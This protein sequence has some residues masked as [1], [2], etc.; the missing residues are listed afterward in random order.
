MDEILEF[1]IL[2]NSFF[3]GFENLT[4]EDK[5]ES[6]V[7]L[8]LIKADKIEAVS[9]KILA[10]IFDSHNNHGLGNIPLK[11]LF[12]LLGIKDKVPR[13]SK[14]KEEISCFY[15]R[16]IKTNGRM[17]L[18]I[19]ASPYLFLIENKIRHNLDNPLDTYR[20]WVEKNYD[21]NHGFT[22]KYYIVL[23]INKPKEDL[24][25][26]KFVSHH[27]LVSKIIECRGENSSTGS[28]HLTPFIEDYFRAMKNMNT[29]LSEEE[30]QILD[31]CMNNF[32]KLDQLQ[33]FKE[34]IAN[35]FEKNLIDI[36]QEI[37]VFN[38]SK[39]CMDIADNWKDLGVYSDS[40]FFFVKEWACV[41]Q[42]H[43]QLERVGIYLTPYSKTH[44]KVLSR[45]CFEKFLIY[46]KSLKIKFVEHDPINNEFYIEIAKFE[47]MRGNSKIIKKINELISIIQ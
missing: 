8:Q 38:S 18:I 28:T 47:P 33:N 37:E 14:T 17:D 5:E 20:K 19:E 10:Y 44:K 16:K 12:A 40:Q 43:Y 11:A 1:N 29:E 3:E 27:N 13:Y 7:F 41:L 34:K 2:D 21:K 31:F 9:T 23:G 24:K 45:E 25:N 36:V 42:I 6:E 30:S 15:G 4:F 46:L 32:E 35:V 39:V 22:E 26:F